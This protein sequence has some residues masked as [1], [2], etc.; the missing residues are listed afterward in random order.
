MSSAERAALNA[1]RQSSMSSQ[2]AAITAAHDRD[3]DSPS[4]PPSGRI[5]GKLDQ[6]KDENS[7]D[8]KHIK[9][10]ID[11]NDNQND[12]GGGGCGK[13]IKNELKL[14]NIK[15]EIKSEPMDDG[16][17]VTLKSEH[18]HYHGLIKDEQGNNV[19]SDSSLDIK[20]I[21]DASGNIVQPTGMDKKRKCCKYYLFIYYY[22]INI[23]IFI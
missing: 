22:Y 5:K 17:G 4:P 2:M 9:Q 21:I 12:S 20:P 1:P 15:N 19:T 7:M 10:E 8:I 13:N 23:I 14:E 6:I 18:H 16:S 11:D 3:D